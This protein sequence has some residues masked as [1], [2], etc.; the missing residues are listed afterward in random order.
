MDRTRK[1]V[2]IGDDAFAYC[3]LDSLII[4]NSVTTIGKQ[5]LNFNSVKKVV[6]KIEQPFEIIGKSI[7]D[8]TFTQNTF[9]NATL[10]VPKGT[11]ENYKETDGWKDFFFIEEESP[12]SIRELEFSVSQIKSNGISLT[13]SGLKEGT[14]ISVYDT[15]GQM[16]GYT[17]ASAGTIE[18]TTS[19]QRGEIGIVKIGEKSVKILMK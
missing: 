17:V 3:R 4:P 9:N 18:F 14:P 19:L 15:A 12:T 13:I 6:S 7:Y 5:A 1:V 16:V 8:R 2:S 10:Y 11:L